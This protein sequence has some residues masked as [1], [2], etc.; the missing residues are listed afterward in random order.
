MLHSV[1]TARAPQVSSKGSFNRF[2]VDLLQQQGTRQ[3]P[4][5]V[6][7]A[8]PPGQIPS[9]ALAQCIHL[10]LSAA[11]HPSNHERVRLLLRRALAEL[12][13][14]GRFVD[15][16]VVLDLLAQGDFLVHAMKLNHAIS[17]YTYP[18][19]AAIQ[20][21]VDSGNYAALEE[22]QQA[23]GRLRPG[24]P[25]VRPVSLLDVHQTHSVLKSVKPLRAR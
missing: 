20:R 15:F 3:V 14:K 9:A 6:R 5:H 23:R 10:M 11:K 21:I 24:G 12:K 13:R 18:A 19:Q 25:A 22:F 17:L 7:R 8:C 1:V 16:K 2:V 4:P